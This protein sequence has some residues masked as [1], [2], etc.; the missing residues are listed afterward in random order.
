MKR[1]L[2][3]IALMILVSCGSNKDLCKTNCTSIKKVMEQIKFDHA[4]AIKTLE[5]EGVKGLYLDSA[6]ITLVVT[7]VVAGETEGEAKVVTL[8]GTKEKSKSSQITFTLKK[9]DQKQ[10]SSEKIMTT[11]ELYNVIVN[12]ARQFDKD[13]SEFAGLE[14]ESFD[15][16]VAFGVKNEFGGKVGFKILGIGLTIG[17]KKSKETTNEIKLTFK[18]QKEE[19]TKTETIE[20]IVKEVRDD[21]KEIKKKL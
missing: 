17:G 16:V 18:P 9:P 4:E 8:S 19:E 10:K 21:I 20:E 3:T 1:T 5:E 14:K 13:V 12:A 15:V 2:L 6:E 11:S 7:N